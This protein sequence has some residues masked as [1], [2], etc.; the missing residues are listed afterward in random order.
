MSAAVILK[1]IE[2][3]L[4]LVVSVVLKWMEDKKK[5]EQ[6][7]KLNALGKAL[8]AED[9]NDVAVFLEDLGV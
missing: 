2:I 6:A 8:I 5:R 1:L 9:P 7:A 3:V 4:P